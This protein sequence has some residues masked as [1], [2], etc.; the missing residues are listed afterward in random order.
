[1]TY[2]IVIFMGRNLTPPKVPILQKP[3]IIKMHL[4][5]KIVKIMYLHSN[6]SFQQMSNHLSQICYQS[7]TKLLCSLHLGM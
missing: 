1:M 2:F 3:I 6:M 5:T 7:Q 4:D